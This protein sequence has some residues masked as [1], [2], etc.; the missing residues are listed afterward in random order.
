MRRITNRYIIQTAALVAAIIMPFLPPGSSRAA[1]AG[2]DTYYEASGCVATPRYGETIAY[3]ERLAQ[4]SPWISY[5]SFG[6]TP[7]GRELPLL[8]ASKGGH[9]TPDAAHRAGNAVLL[10]AACIHAG[11]PD[12]KDAGLMLF[13]D[14][15]ITRQLSGLLDHV[16]V[17]FIPIFNA[18]GHER[19]GPH[20]RINQNGPVEMGWRVTAQNYNLNRDFLKADAP[21]M[22][23]W[24]RL[25]TNWLPDFFIDCHVTDGADYQYVITYAMDI[26][27][28]MDPALTAWTRDVFLAQFER[29]MAAAQFPVFPYVYFRERHDPRSG[30]LTWI[31][32]PRLSEG[33]TTIQNRPG[34]L[35]ETHMMKPYKQRVAGTYEAIKQTMSLLNDHCQTLTALNRRADEYAA[36]DAFR[37]APFAIQY[38][39]T[40]D[41][42][43]I[44]FLGVEYTKEKSDLTGGTWFQWGTNPDRFAIPYFNRFEPSLDIALP[45]AYII[46]PEWTGVIDRLSLHGIAFGR[47]A[48]A[49]TLA[50][51]SYRFEN[52]DWQERP[53]EGRHMMQFET[54]PIEESRVYPEGSA[55][56]PLGQ[57]TARVIVHIFEPYAPDALIR[58]GFF[59]T[60]FEQKE[61]TEDYV[62]ETMARE[63]LAA[64][65][66]LQKAFE[67]KRSTDEEFSK[68]P[69][70]ILNWFYRR[71]PYWDDRIN[72][73]P[74]GR[75]MQMSQLERLELR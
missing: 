28:T 72:V 66:E 2:W 31:T 15:A 70:A 54:E 6:T 69:R 38:R 23:A 20:N 30:L 74:V 3:C 67:E 68:N 51:Q 58:W 16:T 10:V 59:N 53:Y 49:E 39:Q 71:T 45:A 63:M 40:G 18:D 65:P 13:R 25:F 7:Q 73:Y 1:D 46:P 11:E 37:E 47:L 43:M 21:E 9:F 27:G 24:L 75:I 22:Q 56:V 12:G 14:I 44:D 5:T 61:Y 29:T 64:D 35:I 36:S 50:V 62:M 17:L 8:I 52:P 34:L 41:S 48:S 33:Y 26:F 42:T 57:R 55:V 4:A 32:P 60:I 19:F